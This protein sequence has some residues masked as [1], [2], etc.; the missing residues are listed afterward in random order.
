M[1]AGGPG[2]LEGEGAEQVEEG[3]GQDDDVVDVQI[4]LDDH[5]RQPNALGTGWGV[6]AWGTGR[7]E[8][9]ESARNPREL[10]VALEGRGATETPQGLLTGLRALYSLFF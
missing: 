8:R 6:R 4:G 3:P 7:S 5:G 9:S 2:Q 1:G 10:S